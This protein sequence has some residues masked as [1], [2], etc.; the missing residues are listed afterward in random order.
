[1]SKSILTKKKPE[2]R[3]LIFLK[4]QAGRGAGGRITTRHQGGGAKRL[5]RIC[6]FGQNKINI[7]A[8]VSALEYDPYRTAYLMLLEYKDGEKKIPNRPARHKNRR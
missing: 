1:M 6:D 3:L 2:K 5:Y 8:T 4:N 7:P